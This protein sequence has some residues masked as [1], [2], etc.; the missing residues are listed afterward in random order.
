MYSKESSVPVR[1][2]VPESENVLDQWILIRLKEL[3]IAVT[4]ASDK[5]EMDRAVRPVMDFVDDLSTWYL[6]RSR[7]RFKSANQKD[8]VQAIQST[9]FVLEELTKVI[10]PVMP[11]YADELYQKVKSFEGMESVHLAAWPEAVKLTMADETIKIS[12]EEVR[13]IVSLGLEARAKSNIKVRQPLASLKVKEAKVVLSDL[14]LSLIQDEINVKKV[15][16]DKT[17]I[18]AVELD[19]VITLELKEE[20][21]VRELTR[22]IQELRKLEKL[23]PTDLVSLK[24]QTDERGKKLVQKFEAEIK[25]TTLLK[26]ISFEEFEVELATVVDDLSFSLKINQ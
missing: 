22:A 9:R 4:N 11:F 20:G 26:N 3:I 16:F 13:K 25:K 12:M 14:Y 6:R 24:I 1:N 2:F 19:L 18:E 23:S 5:Y 21:S 17:I 10:A 15:V 8:K 7:D